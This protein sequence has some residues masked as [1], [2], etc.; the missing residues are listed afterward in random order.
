M[1]PK[2]LLRHP[3]AKS[4]FSDMI[5]GTTFKRII[6]DD[7]EAAENAEK[8]KKLIF[9]TGKVYY[10]LIKE[11]TKKELDSKIAIVRVEQVRLMN[12][13]EMYSQFRQFF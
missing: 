8:V 10:E 11:R 9:C 13:L 6:P 4:S 1:T 5:E 7:G 2:S 3:D 12:D